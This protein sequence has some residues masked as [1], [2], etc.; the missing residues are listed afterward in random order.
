MEQIVFVLCNSSCVNM[1]KNK[2]YTYPRR[3][4]KNIFWMVDKRMASGQGS[5]YRESN[6]V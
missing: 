1:F 2:V 3:A 4:W 5:H 6:D